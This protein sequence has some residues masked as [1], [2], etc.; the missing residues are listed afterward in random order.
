MSYRLA[1]ATL[2][3]LQ[4]AL[5]W[6]KDSQTFKFWFG[7]NIALGTSADAIWEK[8][9]G[10]ERP[11][12]AFYAG[13]ELVGFGQAYHKVDDAIHI[14][15]LIVNAEFRGKGVGKAFVQAL[16][17]VAFAEP[18]VNTITL[19]VYPDNTPARK[20]YERLGYQVAGEDRGMVAMRLPRPE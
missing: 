3:T 19:N 14:A 7:P 11:S 4:Q 18:Q 15:C 1:P 2:D 20:L 6:A 5:E 17:E 10:D 12:Y 13:D 8:I 16:M 9:Q